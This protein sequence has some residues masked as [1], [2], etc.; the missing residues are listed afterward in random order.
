LGTRIKARAIDY[1]IFLGVYLI[2]M[3]ISVGFLGSNSES[4]WFIGIVTLVWLILCVFYDLVC[5]VF[6]NGQSIGKK[7]SKIKVISLNGERPTLS[8]YMLRWLFRIVDFGVTFGTGAVTSVAVSNH[9]QRFGDIVAGT[10]VIRTEAITRYKDL[11]FKEIPLD[12]EITYQQVSLL[13]D[14]DLNL[15]HDVFGNFSRTK[16]SMLVYKLAIRIKDYL[17]VS[18]P[19][20]INE[21]RFLE[22]IVN[23]YI[24]YTTNVEA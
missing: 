10:V 15:I 17:H 24:S 20:E 14:E 23:D 6:F 7:V 2:C 9:K 8:Q 12:Y 18:Y 19:K 11:T 1:S 13:T 5:E 3:S 21:Y 16:N 4:T 22:I